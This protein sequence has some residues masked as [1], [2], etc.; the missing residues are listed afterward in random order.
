MIC[1]RCRKLYK[2]LWQRDDYQLCGPCCLAYLSAQGIISR[3]ADTAPPVCLSAVK[4]FP[5]DALADTGLLLRRLWDRSEGNVLDDLV[6][7]PVNNPRDRLARHP[8]A[9]CYVT[10][11]VASSALLAGESLPCITHVEH[12]SKP[13]NEHPNFAT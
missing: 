9:A 12:D 8:I 11:L 6:G 10:D 13:V 1:T 7:L 2:A 3:V 5:D 4:G